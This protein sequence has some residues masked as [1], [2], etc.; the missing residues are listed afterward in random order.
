MQV[1]YIVDFDVRGCDLPDGRS[2]F[3]ALLRH[4][5]EWLEFGH[6]DVPDLTAV[7]A[8][9]ACEL[10]RRGLPPADASWT[11]AEGPRQLTWHQVRT[12]SSKA[13]RIDLRA[14]IPGAHA[15][16]V[17]GVTIAHDNTREAA[18]L[19]VVTGR[20]SLGGW[21][22]PAPLSFLRQP[23]VVRRV[24]EDPALDVVAYGYPVDGTRSDVTT[25]GEAQVLLEALARQERL[26]VLLV[27]PSHVDH[28]AF[29]DA[30]ALELPGLAT[31]VCVRSAGAR[32]ALA[33]RWAG[34]ALTPGQAR[35]VWPDAASPRH[36]LL[37]L[38]RLEQELAGV[39][40]DEL[41]RTLAPLS[42]VARG[43]DVPFRRVERAARALARA[44]L[45]ARVTSAGAAGDEHAELAALRAQA[46]AAEQEVE[47]WVGEVQ[48]L[49]AEVAALSE[50]LA[51]P[52]WTRPA[53][54]ALPDWDDAPALDPSDAGP[55][56]D[57]LE[58]RSGGRLRFTAD[59]ARTWRKSGY[60]HPHLMRQALV[61]LARAAVAFAN[62]Q[63]TITARLGDWFRETVGLDVATTDLALKRSGRARFEFEGQ[64]LDG[65]PHV[66]LGDAKKPNECGRIYFAHQSEPA[67]FVVH[68]VGVHDLHP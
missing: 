57:F 7:P 50:A 29:A 56:L 35:L 34:L 64:Q 32:Q 1:Q 13:V 16:H 59:V 17:T 67:R 41:V 66:K 61:D 26:P 28:A 11:V 12:P 43:V 46:A 68:H 45:A 14:P 10:R 38:G 8:D 54:E 20:E 44:E 58:Q 15:V 33:Q 31:V 23:A 18:T 22:A 3:D 65:V 6:L 47:E 39:L 36:P 48:R 2:V 21:I 40:L 5:Q 63:G 4:V 62:A 51:R 37:D 52:A 53:E 55:L 9:G 49:E 27:A 30:A 25:A 19:R 24:V 42:V 60:A